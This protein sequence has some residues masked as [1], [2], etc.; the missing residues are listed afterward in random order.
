MTVVDPPSSYQPI[1]PS[2]S[3]TMVTP[4]P[5]GGSA[6]RASQISPGDDHAPPARTTAGG[7]LPENFK[8]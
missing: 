3:L 1:N 2:V 5:S 7:P 4:A 6:H 8:I